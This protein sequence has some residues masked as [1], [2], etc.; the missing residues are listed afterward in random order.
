MSADRDALEALG[1]GGLG[2]RGARR[3]AEQPAEHDRPQAADGVAVGDEHVDAVADQ[4]RRE[5]LAEVGR[6]ARRAA[7]V[8]GH[9]PGDRAGDPAAVE[10]ERRDEVEHEQ[11]RRWPRPVKLSRQLE[12]P[13]VAVAVEP[14]RR[15]RSRRRRAA[16]I[17]ASAPTHD[18]QRASPAGRRRRRGTPRPG[19]RCRGSS[20]SRRRRRTGRCRDTSIPSRRATSAC[21]SSCSRI[22]PK[23]PNA[24]S[25]RHDEALL[26]VAQLVGERP[27]EPEDEQEQD[28]E[29]RDVDPDADPEDRRQADGAATEHWESMVA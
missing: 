17:E 25:D 18:D 8:A 1:E 23:K 14:R 3:R 5:A 27:L 24:V 26:L 6:R 15:P 11:Q 28:E 20:S 10:R 29:P 13:D 16:P 19:C 4:Q 7:A 2:D 21:P 22:E 9:L 12:R